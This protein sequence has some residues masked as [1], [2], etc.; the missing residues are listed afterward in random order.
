MDG[1]VRRS[2]LA[3]AIT[4][5]PNL[6]SMSSEE[7]QKFIDEVWGLQGV[8]YVVVV[9]RY[10]SRIVTLGRGK[11][12]LDDYLIALATV[13]CTLSTYLYHESLFYKIAD[14]ALRPARVHSRVNCSLL[15]RRLLERPCQ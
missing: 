4:F 9:L 14:D 6:H 1:L 3:M 11:L 12:A 13:S 7:A 2:Q 15:R 10:Y 5:K 8:A